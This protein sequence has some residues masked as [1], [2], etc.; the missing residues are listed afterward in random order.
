MG[1]VLPPRQSGSTGRGGKVQ[2]R[3]QNPSEGR[4]RFRKAHN[5][6]TRAPPCP[7]NRALAIATSG[8]HVPNYCVQSHATIAK[9]AQTIATIAWN[10]QL[11]HPRG[12]YYCAPGTVHSQ[13]PRRGGTLLHLALNYCV[14][15]IDMQWQR[16]RD[17]HAKSTGIRLPSP[18]IASHGVRRGPPRAGL[19]SRSP[20]SVAYG[21]SL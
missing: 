2:T 12:S 21:F 18:S 1:T 7:Q 19:G 14:R 16:K 6:P 11:L 20:P 17:P 8:A 4:A 10:H 13:K 3:A 9:P 15:R 5:R